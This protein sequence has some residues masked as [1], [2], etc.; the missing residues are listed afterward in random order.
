MKH[1]LEFDSYEHADELQRVIHAEDMAS[2]IWD[3]Q[4]YLR[5]KWKY[6]EFPKDMTPDDLINKIWDDWHDMKADA[7]IDLDRLWS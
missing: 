7:G 6:E 4:Q 1:I 3:F 2:F 5:N